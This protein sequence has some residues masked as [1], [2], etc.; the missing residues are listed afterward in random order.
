MRNLLLA[1]GASVA[2]FIAVSWALSPISAIL[3]GLIVFAVLLWWLGRRTVDAVQAALAPVAGMVQARRFE[4]ARALLVSVKEQYA[5]T[6]VMLGGQLDAQIGQLD[7]H[8]GRLDQARELLEAG[9][10]QDFGARLCLGV[11]HQRQGRKEEAKTELAEATR[12]APKEATTWIVR[13][14]VAYRNGDRDTAVAAVTEG[15]TQCP[16]NEELTRLFTEIT[17]KRRIELAQFP[18][19]WFGFFPDD[20]QQLQQQLHMGGRRAAIPGL[21]HIPP[22]V[23]IGGMR[24]GMTAPPPRAKGK[25]ARRR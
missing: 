10:D 12:L 16:S 14:M 9:K 5:G 20:A 7:F 15:H 13:T 4:E 22:G 23:T 6:Q 8:M 3:P 18:Q 2:V 11:I 24:N 25:H 21:E 17:N 1:A 19:L